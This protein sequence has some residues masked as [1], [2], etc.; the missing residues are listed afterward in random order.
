MVDNQEIDAIDLLTNSMNSMSFL[1]EISNV[2]F[3]SDRDKITV[4]GFYDAWIRNIGSSVDRVP[5]NLGIILGYL[6]CGFLYTKENWDYLLPDIA[7]VDADEKYGIITDNFICRVQ[8]P[9]VRYVVRRI[10]NA[11]AHGNIFLNVPDYITTKEQLYSDVTIR[12][13]DINQKDSK[14]IFEIELSIN[15]LTKFIHTFQ[16][17]IYQNVKSRL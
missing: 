14:D 9:N 7:F 1:Y 16:E 2:I 10:R 4:G 11:L 12:F 6:Y 5:I 17:V 3:S 8:N 13:K 15:Q